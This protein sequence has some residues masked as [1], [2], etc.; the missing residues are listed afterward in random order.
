M[1]ILIPVLF[2]Y[3]MTNMKTTAT[4]IALF[5]LYCVT[6]KWGVPI[7]LLFVYF[8]MYKTAFRFLVTPWKRWL[9]WIIVCVLLIT[10]FA[11]GND[12][13]WLVGVMGY[14]FWIGLFE[15]RR[16][17]QEKRA[18]KEAARQYLLTSPS[19]VEEREYQNT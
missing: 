4:V 3:F 12:L 13:P 14:M 11:I 2:F 19:R 16:F 1:I 7:A 5:F 18:E 17:L 15:L 8:V 9:Y 6:A 10:P